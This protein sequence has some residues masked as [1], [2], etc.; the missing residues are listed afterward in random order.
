MV[1]STVAR[2]GAGRFEKSRRGEEA[3]VG[4]GIISQSWSD[5]RM[6]S[7]L[8]I[9]TWNLI[10][11]THVNIDVQSRMPCDGAFLL[12]NTFLSHTVLLQYAMHARFF[13]FLSSKI[14]DPDSDTRGVTKNSTTHK[15]I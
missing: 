7:T 15:V 13:Y 8:R 5:G 4:L 9:I 14:Y 6:E 1:R 10:T 11:Q 12:T 3:L 2:E